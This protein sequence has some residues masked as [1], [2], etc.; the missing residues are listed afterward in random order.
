M[1]TWKYFLRLATYDPGLYLLDV[2]LATLHFLVEMLPALI[3]RHFLDALAGQTPA[4]MNSW[5]LVALLTM[6][7]LAHGVFFTGNM[8][9]DA[10]YRF[11]VGALLRRNLL[12]RILERPGARPLPSSAGEAI[13]RFSGDVDEIM[14]AIILVNQMV[15]LVAYSAILLL[16]EGTKIGRATWGE[17]V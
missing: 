14:E 5:T 15:G 1:K 12:A 6:S 10:T 13:S 7:G 16:A 9:F 4:G 2:L 3:A 11:T 8:F 17:I